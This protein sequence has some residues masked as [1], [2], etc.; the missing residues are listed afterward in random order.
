MF[1]N[2]LPQWF[3]GRE[4]NPRIGAFDI[5]SF[6]ELRPGIILWLVVLVSCACKQYDT[7]GYVSAS[8]WLVVGFESLYIVDSVYNEVRASTYRARSHALL[9]I[10]AGCCRAR[11]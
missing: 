1:C 6:N 9:I 11:C 8:M 7:F 2:P 5:K 3:I 10:S 4:L